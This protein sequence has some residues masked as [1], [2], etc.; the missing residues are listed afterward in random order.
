[1]ERSLSSKNE[2]FVQTLPFARKS[3]EICHD[4]KDFRGK[5]REIEWPE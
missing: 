4:Y 5:V 1:M 2:E 3:P